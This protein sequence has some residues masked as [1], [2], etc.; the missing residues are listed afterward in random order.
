M[1]RALPGAGVAARAF[2]LAFSIGGGLAALAIAAKLSR[3]DEFDDVT[4]LIFGR[5]RK[6]LSH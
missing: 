5:V 2:R 1:D 3:I 6:L 4:S